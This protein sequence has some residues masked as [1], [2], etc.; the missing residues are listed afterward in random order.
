MGLLRGTR[1][2]RR[3]NV[4]EV[5]VPVKSM[6]AFAEL[7]PRSR[8]DALGNLARTTQ[9]LLGARAI[10]NISSTATGGGVA[11]ML[12]PLLRYSRGLGIHVRWLVIEGPPEFFRITKRVHNALHDQPG[13]GSPLGTA[14]AELYERVLQENAVALDSFVRP[15]DVV[16][17][18]DPQTAGLLPHLVG[19]GVRVVWR[20]HIGHER[21]GME[22]D[23][24]WA[25]LRKYVEAAPLT[26]FSRRAYAPSWI[27]RART[28]VLA[29]TIDPFA[30]KN[31]AMSPESV[32][33]I[34]GAVGI[35]GRRSDAP[36][37][38]YTRDD[39]SP[40]RVDHMAEVLRLGPPPDERAPLVVQVSRWD[41]MKDPIGILE[42]F[43]KY[44]AGTGRCHAG[45]VIAGPNTRAVA[46][47]PE[48]PQVF[49]EVQAAWHALPEA[50]RK[51]IHLAQ[52]PMIDGEE[53]AAI[54]NALQRHAAIV[55]Q[56]SL[57]EGFGLTV[58]EAMWK[59]RP[60][61]ASA[62]GGIQDQIVDGQD[63]LLLGDPHD[64]SEL[65]AALC[66]LLD[67]PPFAHKLGEAAHKRVLDSSLSITSLESWGGLLQSLLEPRVPPPVAVAAPP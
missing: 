36:P 39:G 17:C 16:I 60:V 19:R 14:E 28:V 66:Q 49:D 34:L 64:F 24:G 37:A 59:S 65:G 13:D 53:N 23:V 5:N 46:D 9:E 35:I 11:E 2:A 63:G 6:D 56:K 67:D 47:D 50:H 57:R 7:V 32:K 25:F 58:T 27:P 44:V 12:R 55:V 42:G 3:S 31:V 41:R 20:C 43:A 52:L 4:F 62:V 38:M 1:V 18:H 45:L 51:T 10:W 48:G 40:G 33:S 61:V 29:P 54:V 26:V 21:R 15:E 30:A 22:L 8:L